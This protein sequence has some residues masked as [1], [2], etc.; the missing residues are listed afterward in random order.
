MSLFFI[1]YDLRKKRGYQ[2]LY[3]SLKRLN[4]VKILESCWCFELANTSAESLRNYFM[5]FINSKDG[6]IVSQVNDWASIRTD[7]H[8]NN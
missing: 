6:L 7:G 8:P 2:K 4:A 5:R 1:N 3:D